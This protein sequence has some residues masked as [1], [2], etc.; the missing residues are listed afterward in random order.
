MKNKLMIVIC[1]LTIGLS[2][3]AVSRGYQMNDAALNAIQLHV[4]TENDIRQM[5]GEPTSV[6]RDSRSNMKVL[7][8]RHHN[9]DIKSQGAAVLGA[10]AGGVL[11]YQIGQGSGQAL[12]TMIGT[13]AG[14]VLAGNMVGN[15]EQEQV[16]KVVIDTRTGRV[17]DYNYE[18][19]QD[20]RDGIRFNQGVGSF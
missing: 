6:T 10:I 1:A 15:R 11:G 18:Q 9:Q 4:T 19:Y 7:T 17:A 16:L 2:G 5:F 13:T 8:Y 14:G 20:R 12:A 3:C